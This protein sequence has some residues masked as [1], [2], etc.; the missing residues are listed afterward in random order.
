M[1][2]PAPALKRQ[3]GAGPSR[4]VPDEEY[5][6]GLTEEDW[7]VTVTDIYGDQFTHH[8]QL[9]PVVDN[10]GQPV[11]VSIGTFTCILSCILYSEHHVTCRVGDEA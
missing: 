4:A 5:G 8:F 1:P 9:V 10:S 3:D 11:E 6:D 7:R 2:T